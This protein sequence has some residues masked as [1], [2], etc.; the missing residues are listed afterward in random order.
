MA[1]RKRVQ[2]QSET[3]SELE[4]AEA[5]FARGMC[6]GHYNRDYRRRYDNPQ[7]TSHAGVV[8]VA[9]KGWGCL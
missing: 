6:K 9:A 7:G 2:S 5:T 8:R 1:K 3:C 4:C